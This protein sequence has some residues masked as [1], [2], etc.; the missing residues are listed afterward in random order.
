MD[1][2]SCFA[3]IVF[4]A[5]GESCDG[6]F[7]DTN[8]ILPIV[9]T[10]GDEWSVQGT[11]AWKNKNK[12]PPHKERQDN[13]CFKKA[14][15]LLYLNRTVYAHNSETEKWCKRIND[16]WVNASDS[17]QSLSTTQSPHC[18]LSTAGI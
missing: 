16:S 9:D 13:E 6:V 3:Y 14:D 5:N 11:S 2:N 8:S 15:K 4:L 18:T 1:N 10:N 7:V 17:E 12:N